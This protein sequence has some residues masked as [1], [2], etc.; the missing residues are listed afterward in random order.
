MPLLNASAAA[1]TNARQAES[2]NTK[3]VP[4]GRIHG[5][6]APAD[7]TGRVYELCLVLMAT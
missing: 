6:H 5:G 2:F 3:P 1:A 7:V 4:G